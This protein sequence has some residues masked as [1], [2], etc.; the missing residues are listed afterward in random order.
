M[1]LKTVTVFCG[2]SSGNDPR[3]EES[4]RALGQCLVKNKINLIYGGG[5]VGLMGTVAKTVADGGCDVTGF[6][7]EFFVTRNSEHLK[8]IGKT[9]LV[10]DMHTR[11]R[12]MLEQADALIALPGGYGTIEE[13]LEMITWYQL[14][15][16][17]KPIGV[18][19]VANYWGSLIEWIQNAV[20]EGFVYGQNKD[21]LVVAD[22]CETLLTKLQER[23]TNKEKTP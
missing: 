8:G 21:I 17:D 2:S 11:K 9:V 7:P 18:L 23:A 19:N 6:L 3:F 14:R 12:N 20:K 22:D 16:H 1:S 15:L 5:S 4:A 10:E 13:L